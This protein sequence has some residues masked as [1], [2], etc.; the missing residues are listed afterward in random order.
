LLGII[1]DRLDSGTTPAAWQ[2]RVVAEL[3][4]K[5]RPEALKELVERYLQ[6]SATGRPVADW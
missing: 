5:P 4:S 1:R 3:A 6:E 2:R